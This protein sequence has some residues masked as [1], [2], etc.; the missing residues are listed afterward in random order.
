M[1]RVGNIPTIWIGPP[2]WCKDT[3]INDILLKEMGE[4]AYFPSYT[5]KFE[6]KSDKHHPT[7]NSAAN[8][9]DEVI[10]WMNGGKSIH[11][12]RLNV[13]EKVNHKH[14]TIVLKPLNTTKKN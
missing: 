10:K 12:F 3:G 9:M 5:L 4:K 13:P 2:N 6:R 8:W 1:S 7:R 11:P 14:H